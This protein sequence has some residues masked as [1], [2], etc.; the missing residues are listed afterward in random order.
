MTTKSKFFR[1]ATE[2]ATTDGR[3]I[4]RA[5]IEQIAATFNPQTYGARVWLEHYRS[6]LP[7]GPFKAYG[8]V[9]ALKSE[10][11]ETDDGK[12]LALFA[13]IQPTPEL[14]AINQARQKLYTSLEINPKFAD[15]GKPYLVGL[16]VTDTP[17]SLGTDVLKFTAHRKLSAENLFSAGIE[18]DLIFEDDNTTAETGKLT[19]FVKGLLSRFTAKNTGDT[20]KFS[21]ITQAVEAL[22]GHVAKADERHANALGRITAGEIS[23][24]AAQEEF[25]AFKAQM[26]AEAAPTANRPTA[27]GGDGR[28]Q[29]D[30]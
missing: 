19:E 27:T 11:V 12:K 14:I 23:L 30:Y 7:D 10:E 2:G 9:L 18:V 15:T 13:Q 1:V 17:A 28:T 16:A 21:D 5:T 26:D 4:D 22:A 20:A 8:D 25:A 6:I 29:T 3:N 24:K